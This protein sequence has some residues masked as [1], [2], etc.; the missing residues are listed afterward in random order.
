MDTLEIINYIKNS[1]KSTKAICYVNGKIKRKSDKIFI[2]KEK[3][4]AIL[5][6]ELDEINKVLVENKKWISNYYIDVDR[7]NSKVPLL[8]ITKVNARIEPGAIIRDLVEIGDNAVIMMGAV[9]NIGAK[10]GSETMIDMNAVIGGRAEIGSRCHIGACSVIAGV[11]EPVSSKNVVIEDD[12]LIGAGSVILE[13]VRVG[14]NS[15]VGAG[16]IVLKD[17]EPGS[18]VAGNPARFIKR[19]EE[20]NIEKSRIVDDLRK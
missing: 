15:V 1:K 11:I 7:R 9:I 4:L 18:V 10:I 16:S 14:K 13:G 5:I 8:D 6:G 3:S 19:I 20:L 12:C 2:L 17:V